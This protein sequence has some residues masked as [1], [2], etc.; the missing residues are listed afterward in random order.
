MQSQLI[1]SVTPGLALQQVIERIL[2]SG[3]IT[4]TERVWF[5]QIIT[6]DLVIDEK[7]MIQVRRVFERLQMGLIKVI[8]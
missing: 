6:T 5:H 3:Q 8:D 1:D 2:N 4:S 7:T